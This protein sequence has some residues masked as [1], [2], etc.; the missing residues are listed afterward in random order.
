MSPLPSQH[1][2]SRHLLSSAAG[3]QGREFFSDPTSRLP[4]YLTHVTDCS[5]VSRKSKDWKADRCGRDPPLTCSSRG[6]LG[7]S[8][9]SQSS[10][11]SSTHLLRWEF[12]QGAVYGIECV[13]V[14]LKYVTGPALLCHSSFR[15]C[16]TSD[17]CESQIGRTPSPIAPSQ[18]PG[19]ISRSGGVTL[20][21]QP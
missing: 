7:R 11:Q 18:V 17:P 8:V 5:L 9:A 3:R 14:T 12:L 10:S 13:Q 15:A 4:V 1:A 20:P 16:F 19:W 2:S 21:L 6:T